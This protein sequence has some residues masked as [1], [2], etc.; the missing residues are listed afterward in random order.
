MEI[1]PPGVSPA[2]A[3]HHRDH[4]LEANKRLRREV[5]ERIRL[6][7]EERR[8]RDLSEIRLRLTAELARTLDLETILDSLVSGVHDLL[9]ADLVAVLLIDDGEVALGRID[10]ATD[11]PIDPT[12]GE[13]STLRAHPALRAP[14]IPVNHGVTNAKTIGP[15]HSVLAIEMQTGGELV[16]YLLFESRWADCYAPEHSFRLRGVPEQA[17][18][19]ISNVRLKDRAAELAAA[20]ERDRLRRD[21]HDSVVQTLAATN[22]IVETE[23]IGLAADHPSRPILERIQRLADDANAEI[24]ELLRE[25]RE[26]NGPPTDLLDIVL[27][28][29]NRPEWPFAIDLTTNLS[30]AKPNGDTTVAFQH[31]LHEALSNALRHSRADRVVIELTDEPQLTLR[32][33][34]DGCGFEPAAVADDGHM[35]ISIMGER[36]AAIGADLC[37]D[38]AP[39]RG[40]R[41]ELSVDCSTY[42]P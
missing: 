34:D 35:G 42:V 9:P 13:P 10:A 36:A 26:E 12:A 7:I 29:A 8:L 37:I 22:Y 16:G 40:T 30:S 17:A 19:V 14:G 28:L 41:L 1:P 39:G 38:T 25:L 20:A 2:R 24:R 31:I 23:L 3:A 6:Q 18:A 11:Y 21:L 15:A 4:L 33:T 27:E 32:V 5:E